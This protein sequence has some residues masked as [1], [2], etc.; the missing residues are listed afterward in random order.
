M[1]KGKLQTLYVREY[2]DRAKSDETEAHF[3]VR[4]YVGAIVGE[5]A[6]LMTQPTNKSA[7]VRPAHTVYT[8]R[9]EA[10][11]E[12]HPKSRR[13]YTVAREY[14]SATD[15]EY[16]QIV[17][18]YAVLGSEHDHFGKKSVKLIAGNHL[19]RK[20][21]AEVFYTLPKA[22]RELARAVRERLDRVTREAN[23]TAADYRDRKTL[24]RRLLAGRPL[25]AKKASSPRK[26][27]R[28]RL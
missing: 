4:S 9:N 11:R 12:K 3:N 26:L 19:D 21:A 25:P 10:A 14:D 7:L 17:E 2:Y 23:E 18:R 1:N 20:P 16:P 5:H 8:S 15:L 6:F 22:K 13:C 28:R 24:L 27:R